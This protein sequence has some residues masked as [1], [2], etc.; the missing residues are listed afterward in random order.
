MTDNA[1]IATGGLRGITEDTPGQDTEGVDGISGAQDG[2]PEAAQ[3]GGE[4]PGSAAQP[5]HPQAGA[6]GPSEAGLVTGNRGGVTGTSD[7]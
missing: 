7:P 5:A 1:D 2:Q 4:T 3:T 6:E